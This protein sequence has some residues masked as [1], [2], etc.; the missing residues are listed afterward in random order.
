MFTDDMV[1]VARHA[2]GQAGK[3]KVAERQSQPAQCS[4][5]SDDV[6]VSR[7]PAV[8]VSWFVPVLPMHARRVMRGSTVALCGNRRWDNTSD[9]VLCMARAEPGKSEKRVCGGQRTKEEVLQRGVER[10][11]RRTIQALL[12]GRVN[13]LPDLAK[14]EVGEA[15]RMPEVPMNAVGAQ[16]S[17]QFATDVFQLRGAEGCR[18]FQRFA[19]EARAGRRLFWRA[20]A[21]VLD[22]NQRRKAETLS[23][24]AISCLCFGE[25]QMRLCAA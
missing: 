16:L 14:A 25:V 24:I 4:C 18:A 21:P 6:S 20:A 23:R 1:A 7:V 9:D 19:V 2:G 22:R 10:R 3:Y 8:L 15:R 5:E 11:R 13:E 12:I 17:R